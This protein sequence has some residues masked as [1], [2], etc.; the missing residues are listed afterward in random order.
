MTLWPAL[1]AHL[2]FDNDVDIFCNFFFNLI[3][4]FSCSFS[5]GK[6]ELGHVHQRVE[7]L[8]PQHHLVRGINRYHLSALCPN[9][10]AV[11]RPSANMILM[12]I[13]VC[14]CIGAEYGRPLCF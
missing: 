14:S 4:A 10:L 8:Q 5:Q 9:E 7:Q 11:R 12:L 13:T 2:S 3:E 6:Q 1:I